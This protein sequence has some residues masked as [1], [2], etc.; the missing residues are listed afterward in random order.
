MTYLSDKESRVGKAWNKRGLAGLRSELLLKV[1]ESRSEGWDDDTCVR[2]IAW[3]VWGS[4]PKREWGRGE[5]LIAETLG[6]L[7]MD[8]DEWLAEIMVVRQDEDALREAVEE[9]EGE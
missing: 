5:V 9:M 3:C 8:A 4:L 2:M 6:L 1:Q 7:E